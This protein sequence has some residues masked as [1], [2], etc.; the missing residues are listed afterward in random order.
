VIG[1]KR[2]LNNRIRSVLSPGGSR[3]M[4]HH[5]S[6][7][8]SLLMALPIFMIQV[9]NSTVS[10]HSKSRQHLEEESA[11]NILILTNLRRERGQINLSICLDRCIN[12]HFI[13]SLHFK[14]STEVLC[15]ERAKCRFYLRKKN[16]TEYDYILQ[17]VVKSMTIS[18]CATEIERHFSISNKLSK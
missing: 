3:T 1:V 2:L 12:P 11:T 13:I 18:S 5:N 10:L 14:V 16:Q 15:W 6:D 7:I 17:T 9:G 8:P 4:Q